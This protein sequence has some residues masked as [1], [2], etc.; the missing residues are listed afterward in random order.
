MD[1]L[2]TFYISTKKS[3]SDR[4]MRSVFIDYLKMSLFLKRF[5]SDGFFT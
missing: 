3:T 1:K 2:L 4:R 5:H